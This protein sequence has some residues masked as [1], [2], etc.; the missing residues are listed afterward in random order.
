MMSRWGTCVGLAAFAL[1][2]LGLL[3]A[4]SSSS[5]GSAVDTAAAGDAGTSDANSADASLAPNPI[6]SLPAGW[7]EVRPGG[8]TA[9]SDGS[10]FAFYVRPGTIDRVVF[11]FSGGGACWNATTCGFAGQLFSKNV[12]PAELPWAGGAAPGIYDHANPDNPFRDWHHVFVP[13]C[14]GDIHWGDNVAK[15][16]DT[17]SISHVGA[18]NA[19]AALDWLYANVLHTE[20]VMMTGCSAGGYGSIMWTPYVRQHYG[21]GTPVAQFSDSAAGVITSDFFST[22]QESWRYDKVLP[23][24]VPGLEKVENVR[25]LSAVYKGVGSLYPDVPLAEFNTN[26]DEIQSYFFSVLG[27]GDVNQWSAKMRAEITDMQ[28]S[29]PSFRGITG[30]G[31]QH[32]II[33]QKEFYS[34]SFGG[35]KLTDWIKKRIAN[36]P[37]ANSDCGSQC[38]APK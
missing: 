9:C 15:Y 30:P 3:A 24:F 16:S 37:V 33:N 31:Y 5:S 20:N 14:T 23:G 27:G 26:F 13:Y 6:K 22:I 10:P 17:L 1:P 19:R 2:L 8:R 4:C 18:V 28:A 38:G 7:N 36:E 25:A 34:A 21:T 11:E 32:C 29:V 12:D 35:V